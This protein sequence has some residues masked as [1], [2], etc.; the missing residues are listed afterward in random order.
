MLWHRPMKIQI[1]PRNFENVVHP[2]VQR[3]DFNTGLQKNFSTQGKLVPSFLRYMAPFHSTAF[4]RTNW[5][6]GKKRRWNSRAYNNSVIHHFS[7]FFCSPAWKCNV[8][9]PTTRHF[10]ILTNKKRSV[11]NQLLMTLNTAGVIERWGHLMWV[12]WTEWLIVCMSQIE[13]IFSV[14]FRVLFNLC[15]W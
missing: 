1:N 15:W 14:Y 11:R 6:P 5:T 12:N 10:I 7:G 13:E 2:G 8:F 9:N 4:P 3:F